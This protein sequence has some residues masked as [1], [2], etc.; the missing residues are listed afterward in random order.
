MEVIRR[1]AAELQ[2]PLVFAPEVYRWEVRE[3]D[4]AGQTIDV[5][6]PRRRYEALRVALLGRHQVENAVLAVAA[7]EAAQEQGFAL[8]TAAIRRGLAEVA[9]PG[10]L[11]VVK[12]RPR[13]MLD[14]AHNPAGTEALAAFLA[15]HRAALGRLIL[16]FG[17]LQDK[18]WAA[19]LRLLAPLADAIVLTHPPT[20]RAAD[21]ALLAP[22]VRR[23]ASASVA[24]D[25]EGALAQAREAARVEDT[26]LVAGSLYTVAAALRIL[27]TIT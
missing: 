23:Y 18:D 2:A 26:I 12:E 19:M 8:D 21:P 11:Q 5:E 6:G 25:L 13:I 14:G 7:A 1:R 20:E 16:V 9:W 24:P 22:A 27:S 4:L 15:E 10:R 3:S 17:V